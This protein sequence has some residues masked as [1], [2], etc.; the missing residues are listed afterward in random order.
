MTTLTVPD[1]YTKAEWTKIVRRGQK[2]MKQKSG[3]HWALGDLVID[4][5]DGRGRGHGEVNQV[6][7]ILAH[8]IGANPES[9]RSY[10]DV[11]RQWPEAKRREDVSFSVHRTLAYVRS[12]YILIRKDPYDPFT[13]EHRWTVNE[14]EKVA[15]RAVGTPT[16]QAER[17]AHTRRLLRT[18]EDAAKAVTEM[19]GRPD[20]SLFFF[21]RPR[22]VSR[23]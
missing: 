11:A 12:R 17:L 13:K 6:I 1:G 15:H 19:L 14:A 10:Y 7:K 22:T 16:N 8:Q 21:F 18:D 4:A 9:L 2:L 23:T 20:V 5:L 3:I